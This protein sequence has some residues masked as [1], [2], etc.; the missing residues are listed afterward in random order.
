MENIT[1]FEEFQKN[2]IDLFNQIKFEL[3]N[4]HI[5]IYKNDHVEGNKVK[6]VSK[7]LTFEEFKSL[8]PDIIKKEEYTKIFVSHEYNTKD[9]NFI[10]LDSKYEF[11]ENKGDISTT[12]AIDAKAFLKILTILE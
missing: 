8:T 4:E 5:N 6:S 9:A 10:Q 7:R 3:K 11:V 12:V 2:Y 1:S